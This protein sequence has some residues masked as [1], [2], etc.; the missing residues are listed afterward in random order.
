MSTQEQ[1]PL[2]S[3]A[4]A[5]LTELR[6]W[7]DSLP[8]KSVVVRED[9][10]PNYG[11]LLFE[12][13]PATTNAMDVTVGLGSSDEVDLYW[14]D[15]YH[16]EGWKATPG[17]VLEVCEAIKDG[18]VIEETWRLGRFVLE[19]R[20]YIRVQGQRAGDGSFP[21]PQWLKKWARLSV[22]TYSPWLESKSIEPYRNK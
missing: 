11:G 6:N 10:S 3:A 22:R 2:S 19:R 9:H 15:G 13:R 4:L 18:D 8:S 16:W 7:T 5:L 12:V 21:V 14:G 20:C 1:Q 17:E